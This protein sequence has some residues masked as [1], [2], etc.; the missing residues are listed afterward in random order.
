MTGWRMTKVGRLT[1]TKLTVLPGGMALL[2][3]GR[4]IEAGRASPTLSSASAACTPADVEP[5]V[6]PAPLPAL[7]LLPAVLVPALLLQAAITR[8]S[9]ADREHTSEL[10]SHH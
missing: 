10:Q 1:C 9:T 4:P 7:A 5:L 3:A 8:P 2:N 6:T